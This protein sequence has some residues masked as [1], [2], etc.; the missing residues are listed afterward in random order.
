MKC[1]ICHGTGIE[2]IYDKRTNAY[3][4]IPCATCHKTGHINQTNEEWFCQL[5]T[6]QKAKFLGE[7]VWVENN[8]LDYLHR[9]EA[10]ERWL[11][12]PHREE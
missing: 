6:E 12:Q 2:K 3:L 8:R 5:P 7:K 9:A 4:H 11:K 10:W 1:P